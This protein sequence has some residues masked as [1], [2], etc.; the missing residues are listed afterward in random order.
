LIL[1]SGEDY[2]RVN[3]ENYILCKLDKASVFPI[4]NLEEVKKHVIKL[5]EKDFPLIEI[6]KF[7][8]I[9]GPPRKNRI[10][11]LLRSLL[12]GCLGV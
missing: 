5:K 3:T 7:I 9:S 8:L 1:K 4:G 6:Y 10:M 11:I 12:T 2:I